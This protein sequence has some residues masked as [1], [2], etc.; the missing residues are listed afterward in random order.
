M[1]R[2]IVE[3]LGEDTPLH[4]S[5][6][7]PNYKLLN[8]PPTPVETLELA[9]Q[10]AVQEG[11]HYVTIGNVPG[12]EHNSTFC[13]NCKRKIIHRVHFHVIKNNI[14]DG[15]CKFCRYPITGIWS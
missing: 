9:Y 4:F 13:P 14:L 6:F 15:R 1:C 5:R 12:H 3:T 10:T 2:W 8:L 7:H 11:L